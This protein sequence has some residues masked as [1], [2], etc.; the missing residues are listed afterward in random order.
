V[1]A[2]ANSSN[3]AHTTHATKGERRNIFLFPLGTVLFPGGVLPLKIFEQR[4]LHMTKACL[5]DNLPF[6]VCLIREGHEVGAPAVPSIVGCLATI[7]Q[8]E[9]PNL[10]MFH[11]LARGGERFRLFETSIA[12]NGLTSADV[13]MLPDVA[14]CEP[15]AEFVTL[16]KSVIDRLGVENFPQPVK[17]DDGAW[18]A[19]R[20]A[21]MAGLPMAVRQRMLEAEAGSELVNEVKNSIKTNI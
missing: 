10:G 19:Y 20:L 7:E 11:L 16:V 17:L 18:V 1:S 9:M 5:R 15:D 21:E 2:D 12:D 4:Y 8:W 3:A 13:E 6:G 14:P